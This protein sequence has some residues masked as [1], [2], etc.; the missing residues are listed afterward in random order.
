MF[1]E[2]LGHSVPPNG[3]PEIPR[4][5]LYSDTSEDRTMKSKVSNNTLTATALSID[6]RMK[7]DVATPRHD[8]LVRG[9]RVKSRVKAGAPSVSEIVVTKDMDCASTGL[10]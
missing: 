2:R 8:Q 10:M 7:A 1:E 3:N 5:S 4:T 9:L 6:T